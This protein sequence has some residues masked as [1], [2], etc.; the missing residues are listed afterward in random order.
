MSGLCPQI[1]K[2]YALIHQEASAKVSRQRPDLPLTPL[3]LLAYV[4]QVA[5]QH[6]QLQSFLL[7]WAPL[8][9][10]NILAKWI[11]VTHPRRTMLPQ[12]SK[13]SC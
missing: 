8:K 4:A 5:E 12:T 3:D 2:G 13:D 1:L 6:T 9:S 11:R 10:S 7:F